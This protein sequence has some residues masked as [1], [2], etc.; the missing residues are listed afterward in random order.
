MKVLLTILSLA[1]GAQ[2][3]AAT[4][5]IECRRDSRIVFTG[6]V[7]T[8]AEISSTAGEDDSFVVTFREAIS[9]T[10]AYVMDRRTLQRML[11]LELAQCKGPYARVYERIEGGSLL[12]TDL[13]VERQPSV[14]WTDDSLLKTLAADDASCSVMLRTKFIQ[15]FKV[16]ASRSK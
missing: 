3:L 11:G 7:L 16:K 12:C 9:A 2:S 10:P 8:D 15:K 6:L 5:A 13:H 1:I 14:S 4:T